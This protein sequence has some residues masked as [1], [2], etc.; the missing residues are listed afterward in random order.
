MIVP[1]HVFSILE[2]LEKELEEQRKEFR[3]DI[4]TNYHLAQVKRAQ[5]E[6]KVQSHQQY[7][8]KYYY[9]DMMELMYD[10]V[11]ASKILDEEAAQRI[12]EEVSIEPELIYALNQANLVHP[13]M[14]KELN[15]MSDFLKAAA[16][17]SWGHIDR[18]ARF[19]EFK[20]VKT[21]EQWNR[22]LKKGGYDLGANF[23]NAYNFK[24]LRICYVPTQ[25]PSY[26][27]GVA[28][29][30]YQRLVSEF[31]EEGFDKYKEAFELWFRIGT[32]GIYYIY[33][34]R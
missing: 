19:R 26:L 30:A 9:S 22:Y 2:K 33:V 12:F 27:T 20:L 18:E 4:P 32:K 8:S 24:H 13:Y 7:N 28:E 31:G 6:L 25:A 16:N 15:L 23:Q 11:R 5:E 29:K 34:P 10:V 21:K 3:Q 14:V 17:L 1:Q